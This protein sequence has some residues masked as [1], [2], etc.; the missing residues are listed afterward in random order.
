MAKTR[1][2]RLKSKMRARIENLLLASLTAAPGAEAFT[3]AAC[4]YFG[5]CAAICKRQ[6]SKATESSTLVRVKHTLMKMTMF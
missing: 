6:D 1:V 2:V 3:S 4:F 5:G